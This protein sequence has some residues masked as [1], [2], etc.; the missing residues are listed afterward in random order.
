MNFCDI[1]GRSAIHFAVQKGNE[2][3]LRLL[4]KAGAAIETGSGSTLLHLA[5]R[6]DQTKCLKRLIEQGADVN[7]A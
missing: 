3:C 5:V 6:Y 7:A 4:L 2:Q 1:M